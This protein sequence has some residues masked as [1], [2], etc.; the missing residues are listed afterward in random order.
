MEFNP[1]YEI[2]E[3]IL[4]PTYVAE[5]VN[6]PVEYTPLN[7]GANGKDGKDGK[8]GENGKDGKDGQDGQDGYTPQKDVDYHDGQ[9][10]K[11]GQDYVITEADYENIAKYVNAIKYYIITFNGEAFVHDGKILT[12]YEIKTLCLDTEHF[13]YAQYANRLYIPQYI[14]NNNIFFQSTYIDSGIPQIHRISINNNDVVSQYNYNL[15]KDTDI[16]PPYDDTQIKQ[17]INTLQGYFKSDAVKKVNRANL[18]GKDTNDRPFVT[19]NSGLNLY[20]SD[21]FR[22]NESTKELK[23]DGNAVALNKDIPTDAHIK[24]II[25][26]ALGVIINASY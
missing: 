2:E 25:D 3:E 24:A 11:D 22:F 18:G 23:I 12:F 1:T 19:I 7:R 6:Y 20:Y 21:V 13:V 5:S 10:G 15:A 9:D 16:L 4:D 26:E 8:D 14:S 17:D